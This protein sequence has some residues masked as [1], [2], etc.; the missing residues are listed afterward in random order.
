MNSDTSAAVAAETTAQQSRQGPGLHADGV[1]TEG[2]G[3]AA[4]AG[5][6]PRGAVEEAQGQVPGDAG[7]QNEEGVRGLDAG[8]VEALAA[9]ESATAAAVEEAAKAKAAAAAAETAAG[10]AEGA[11]SAE[12]A[13]LAAEEASTEEASTE[14]AKADAALEAVRAHEAT[15]LEAGKA[16]AAAGSAGA[17]A[18]AGAPDLRGRVDVSWLEGCVA[19]AAQARA[20]A[21]TAAAKAREAAEACK[22]SVSLPLPSPPPPPSPSPPA[23]SP[24]P[25]SNP[26][27]SRAVEE[28]QGPVPGAG[29]GQGE[30]STNSPGAG[31]VDVEALAA[32]A[33]N[34][35]A[36]AARRRPNG[37]DK[38]EKE[39]Q[40]QGAEGAG[41]LDVE[42]SDVEAG[43]G[44]GADPE[45]RPSGQRR[46]A[47]GGVAADTI[48]LDSDSEEEAAASEPFVLVYPPNG[49]DPVML[50]KA[51]VER[52]EPGRMFTD[53]IINLCCR[54]MEICVIPEENERRVERGK[55]PLRFL[56]L[57]S[58]LMAIFANCKLK[59]P[60]RYPECKGLRNWTRKA[61]IFNT[62]YLFVIIHSENPLHWTL[63]IVC[64]LKEF[65]VSDVSQLELHK[66]PCILH[67]CSLGLFN[68][69][70]R[71]ALGHIE[72]YVKEA[73]KDYCAAP[74]SISSGSRSAKALTAQA[75]TPARSTGLPAPLLKVHVKVPRQADG[76]NDCGS[77]VLVCIEQFLEQPLDLAGIVD[78]ADHGRRILVLEREDWF[79]KDIVT[80]KREEIKK[81]IQNLK[82]AAEVDKR[83]IHDQDAHHS[84]VAGRGRRQANLATDPQPNGRLAMQAVRAPN[85]N[86]VPQDARELRLRSSIEPDAVT[87][88]ASTPSRSAESGG[89]SVDDADR[90][91]KNSCQERGL[92]EEGVSTEGDGVAAGAGDPPRRAVE[93]VRGQVPGDA[94]GQNEEGG[95]GL[96]AGV[97]EALAAL[98]SATAAAVEEAAKAKAAAAA[99]ETAA[100]KAEGA[101]SAEEAALAA[102]EASTEEAKA[103]AALEAVRAHEATA[104]E[105]GKAAAAAASA[106]AAAA[107]GAPALHGRVDVNWLL[108]CVAEAARARTAARMAAAKARE[109]AEARK[110]S[111]QPNPL[112]SWAVEE[113]RGQVPGDAG[114]QNEEGRRGLDAGV[115]EALA[116]LESA[117]AAAVDEA[118]KV[119]AAAA[120][121]ETAAGKAEGA[122]SAEEAALA[123][124]EA[125]TE[126]AKAD[127]ALEAVR[128]HEATALEAGKAA[129]AAASAGAAAAAGAPALHGRVDVNW[130][131]GCVA[132]AAR[133]R[134]AARMAAAKAR[135]A[136]EAR[137]ASVSLPPPNPSP[138]PPP[139]PPAGSL[140]LQP[141]PLGSWAVEEVRARSRGTRADRTRR[142]AAVSTCAR[143]RRPFRAVLTRRQAGVV[144]ALAALE[145]ATAAAVDEAAKVK[146]AAAAA[147]TAAGKAEGAGSAEEAALA[148]EEA[149]TEEAKADAALEAVRAHEATA[150][151]AG[152]AAAAAASAGAA[153]AAGAPALHGRVD[154]NWLLGC[155]AEA[156]RARTAAR[157]AAAK[158]REA[159][160]AR[161]ASVSLPPPNPSPP[162]PPSPPAG[163]LQ[164]QPNPLGSWAVEEVRGQV[165]GDAGGQ[166]EEGGRGL[167]AGVVEALAA[168]ESAT[169]AAVEEAAKAKAAA[170]AAETAA[171]KA[172]GASSAEEAA[173]AAE[174]ASTE[175]AKADAALE[176]VRAHEATALEAGKAA[177]A[178]ASAGAAAAA[179]APALHGRVDVNWLLGCVAEAARAR[180]AA[181][182]AAAKAREAAEA[183]K[184]SVSLPPPNPSPPPPPSPP[185][186]SLQPQPN[187]LG[188]WAVEEVR[189]Q[190]PGD[191]G[192][193]NE[194]GR[195]GLDAGVVEA[196]AALES[197]TAA[198]VEEAAKAKAAAAAAETAA[199]KAEGASSAEEA[200]LAAEEAST[201]EAKADA[202]L[203]A[204]RAHEA[205]ALEAG[206]AAAAAAS[207]GAAAAAGA[208][209]LH[210]RVD[211]N[212]LLGCVADAAR[213]RT[214]ARMAAAKAREAAEAR[215]A[216]VSLP[217][218]NPS[219]PP[220]PSPPAGS[221]QLQPNPLG[222]WAVE[223]VRGQVP[224]DEGGQD[225]DGDGD[226]TA[227]GRSKRKSLARSPG[228]EN[229]QERRR[230]RLAREEQSLPSIVNCSIDIS[231]L[232]S[233]DVDRLEEEARDAA[234]QMAADTG[235]R[236]HAQDQA[237]ADQ[238]SV[239]DAASP[240]GGGGDGPGAYTDFPANAD[241]H[242]PVI[243]QED[244]GLEER[245]APHAPDPLPPVTPPRLLPKG[246]R[247][248]KEP[249]T[250]GPVAG[251]SNWRGNENEAPAPASPSSE[252]APKAQRREILADISNLGYVDPASSKG[253]DPIR[254]ALAGGEGATVQA[255]ADMATYAW[256]KRGRPAAS[257]PRLL[258]E[259][260]PEPVVWNDEPASLDKLIAKL[261]HP[262]RGQDASASQTE[263]NE[264]QCFGRG[265]RRKAFHQA[266]K[267]FEN[268]QRP[269]DGRP[270]AMRDGLACR[271]AMVHEHALQAAGARGAPVL[272]QLEPALE[273]ARFSYVVVDRDPEEGR[274][275]C[276]FVD[277]TGSKTLEAFESLHQASAELVGLRQPAS[278]SSPR[279]P[280]LEASLRSI[281]VELEEC[282]LASRVCSNVFVVLKGE[283][284]HI[285]IQYRA[286][287]PE[288]EEFATQ[289]IAG[290]NHRNRTVKLDVAPRVSFAGH[291]R[292][293]VHTPA[294]KLLKL[295]PGP[296]FRH[297]SNNEACIMVQWAASW[298]LEDPH[299]VFAPVASYAGE[300]GLEEMIAPIK[301]AAAVMKDPA[302]FDEAAKLFES[303]V[304][305]VASS[306][307]DRIRAWMG[308]A[309]PSALCL[310]RRGAAA[311]TRVRLCTEMLAYVVICWDDVIEAQDS[312][313]RRLCRA[314]T[315]VVSSWGLMKRKK[316]ELKVGVRVMQGEQL[317]Q[318]S[319]A[320]RLLVSDL[321]GP[322][323]LSA[324]RMLQNA[325]MSWGMHLAVDVVSSPDR[326]VMLPIISVGMS[327]NIDVS[328]GSAAAAGGHEHDGVVSSSDPESST[329]FR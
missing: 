272:Q 199:G 41:E 126:E 305:C 192:G 191:A 124:E 119:K 60:Y 3:V 14:E 179:G 134:T 99:A 59:D 72:Q 288:Q 322:P 165:P 88:E 141:N 279:G 216:S 311:Y 147:E 113:V 100:G 140:Q 115:V 35:A 171:G 188:S 2:D 219:P 232:V 58:S 65:G 172:E 241:E 103:D 250:P 155:V 283:K 273:K 120:A 7:G 212:W 186:G 240:V 154:V 56:C 137:K 74:A 24:Q 104:L 146:A 317:G 110:A 257:V 47:A 242:E 108:G 294:P 243:W 91:G 32:L 96:D 77:S 90:E 289:Y 117:T 291:P 101:S 11:S 26:L 16:A 230:A 36:A 231:V 239:L 30:E 324:K 129:A 135:E 310:D 127:A 299:I 168:L 253:K 190:V 320:E 228:V 93:E 152:K 259:L 220:P 83:R 69:L 176:A 125:S 266:C 37:E 321:S 153:A 246:T 267:T 238:Q 28:A 92:Q 1:T 315:L 222:S 148:A 50:T 254:A 303:H 132:E 84:D 256:R 260:A 61:A 309:F 282:Q 274:S 34:T 51:D 249:L 278:G 138:P 136:A 13:A 261:G 295:E 197:A 221:L 169:A 45:G 265:A 264:A 97:V 252:T 95:R 262:S 27:G 121:A 202:A 5:D 300:A 244:E 67:L 163:S 193:Q 308:K 187:P 281:G 237:H 323:Q 206:K 270:A 118:A 4:G 236:S 286:E 328:I 215:K 21:R 20:A 298:L 251:P 183:R 223:E 271:L 42:G 210:G 157:M 15:A 86:E 23:G 292:G 76:S 235:A 173:L 318:M 200:A 306:L 55:E 198:A 133:A 64:N 38:V 234:S 82:K 85:V 105:A 52:L 53:N 31:V 122:S 78:Q 158:A 131:L 245:T 327:I 177:A 180:T 204:V 182:M 150:L 329:S 161:K 12:E 319:D 201:E 284:D 185:A 22:A 211:V 287:S 19:E 94:G 54:H 159:A 247:K 43:D 302:K 107:A 156:A 25:N 114:G 18:A 325:L 142:A 81:L 66:R 263:H 194:E 40:Q 33:S 217:P 164:L 205:T 175:E 268:V 106:G 304:G 44:G 196:L 275:A 9:L 207:A 89:P 48:V 128:A 111:L 208:P 184:A 293:D 229:R 307:S 301:S 312:E 10:K 290:F 276:F 57:N 297:I 151:E 277:Y 71:A 112:G 6:P 144:E 189:G 123:A 166:N 49:H 214:A 63:A 149:S 73:W 285:C 87:D 316:G 227:G 226:E 75:A 218:P 46:P 145:S 162:P 203:E 313:L 225:E 248:R 258:E 174:E 8:V 296:G 233:D 160:E 17:A 70:A 195:R 130:L 269:R 170:A 143:R 62:D 224:G 102:E 181:R 109:A 79:S 68:E 280:D 314:L 139:S 39:E 178:A 326:D 213:A 29:G 98:E 80:R 116:A 209:A 167:D 255:P